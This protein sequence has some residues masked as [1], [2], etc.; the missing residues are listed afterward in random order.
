M[1][2]MHPASAEQPAT[3]RPIVGSGLVALAVAMGIGRFAFTPL[4]PLMIRDGTLSP[5]AGAEWA[6]ANYGG[7][8]VGALT[9]SWFADDPRR[10]LLVSLLGVALTT[11]AMAAIEAGTVPLLGLGLR[12]AAGVF[13]AWALVC[14]SGWCLAELARRR[15]GEAGAWIYTG[16]GL[17]IALAGL[18]TW[19]G[20]RQPAQWLWLELG[21]LAGAGALFVRAQSATRFGSAGTRAARLTE[22]EASATAPLTR[23]RQLSLVICYGT[24][25]FGYIVPATFL[26]SM[27]R[28]L[29]PDPLVFG[30][31]WPLFGLAAALS[32]AA[33]A[34]FLTYGSRQRIWAL[35]QGV[36]ALG[37]A[38]PL[39]VQTL[40]AI[41]V[42]AVLVGGTFMVATMAGLQLAREARPDNPTP[43]LAR[44]T[45]AFAAGQI[46]GPLLVRAIGSGRWAGW[47]ALGWT[48]AVATL[49]LILSAAWLW[50]TEHP[51][52]ESP[53]PA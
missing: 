25:G 52:P 40:P 17:G 36:M 45:A 6:A 48:G 39:F 44:M 8:L 13:S 51:A 29:A 1:E 9:A 14:A 12:A 37:T 34:R 19:V 50:R 42:S 27:A 4:M 33:V 30:L 23:S 20:G 28:A 3:I 10:G 38:L 47:D 5:A 26:P 46:A 41:A 7:Y 35:A 43:L 18:L 24:F 22:R 31:T 15:S 2:T 49:L 21:T 53:R 32:V 16:V 11:F